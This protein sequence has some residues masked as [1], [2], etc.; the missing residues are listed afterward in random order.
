MKPAARAAAICLAVAL[1][2]ELPNHLPRA[3]DV[4]CSALR[5]ELVRCGVPSRAL[6]GGRNCFNRFP[7][8]G[9]ALE[10]RGAHYRDGAG[11]E[12]RRAPVWASAF[13]RPWALAKF[14]SAP[15]ARG[16]TSELEAP[17]ARFH[18]NGSVAVEHLRA[19]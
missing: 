10:P 11:L 12:W 5:R 2:L 18:P 15:D 6:H 16:G 14:T 13:H 4:S 7:P 8:P 17:L 3:Q 9:G 19:G 1:L